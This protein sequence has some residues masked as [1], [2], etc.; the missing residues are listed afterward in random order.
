MGRFFDL[1]RKWLQ[2]GILEEDG[3]V[4]HPERAHRKAE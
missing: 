3:K 4:I 2:A 1:I